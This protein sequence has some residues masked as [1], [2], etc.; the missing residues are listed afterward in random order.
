LTGWND[1]GYDAED[2][3]KGM[4]A[5]EGWLT[6]PTLDLAL[7]GP[8]NDDEIAFDWII[9]NNYDT[10][11]YF[12]LLIWIE[13]GE[14]FPALIMRAY[15]FAS[16]NR[17]VSALQ[18]LLRYKADIEAVDPD[19]RTA[20][21]DRIM[22]R[23]FDG[24]RMLLQYGAEPNGGDKP[25]RPRPLLVAM[26]MGEYNIAEFL[27]H[28]GA[29][30]DA[31]DRRGFSVMWWACNSGELG[32]V[33]LVLRHNAAINQFGPDGMTPLLYCAKKGKI[34]LARFLIHRGARINPPA[35]MPAARDGSL[36]SP[37]LLYEGGADIG[38][39][40]NRGRR[41][42]SGNRRRLP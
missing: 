33:D 29:T 32:I 23:D 30:V 36:R 41:A 9:R 37:F 5:I 34:E 15:S 2:I 22:N 4:K 26:W 10:L 14:R 39:T 25:H 16:K 24:V 6:S 7:N 19:G 12:L 35:L 38:L 27:L 42:R 17:K 21:I 18:T 8:R 40:D 28:N 1:D 13:L 3:E 31:L 20:L 11:V